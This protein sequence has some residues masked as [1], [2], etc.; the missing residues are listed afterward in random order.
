MILKSVTT[1][2]EKRKKQMA[3]AL[4]TTVGIIRRSLSEYGTARPVVDELALS[5]KYFSATTQKEKDAMYPEIDKI[6]EEI[7]REEYKTDKILTFEDTLQDVRLRFCEIIEKKQKGSFKNIRNI[8]KTIR[9]SK[10]ISQKRYF[11]N[12]TWIQAC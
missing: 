1:A 3:I 8:F 4:N 2:K 7:A 9:E 12:K 6:L 5:R 10:P 11:C